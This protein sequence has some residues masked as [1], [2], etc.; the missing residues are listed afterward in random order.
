MKRPGKQYA[1]RAR[2]GT[3]AR[4]DLSPHGRLGFESPGMH[5]N[6]D[7]NC[8]G[9]QNQATPI[10]AA[11]QHFLVALREKIDRRLLYLYHHGAHTSYTENN[12]PAGPSRRGN[13][14]LA[15]PAAEITLSVGDF[16]RRLARSPDGPPILGPGANH[17]VL[18]T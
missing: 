18:L 17:S 3:L 13:V 5:L 11:C 16:E 7:M 10:P 1:C 2:I 9:R 15:G 12:G 6:V 8:G 4:T 14:A